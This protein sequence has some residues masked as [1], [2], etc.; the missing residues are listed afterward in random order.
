M[1]ER[2]AG[3]KVLGVVL[4]GIT[5]FTY[6][7]GFMLKFANIYFVSGIS[8]SQPYVE[9]MVI[10]ED[11]WGNNILE[12]T[13]FL[14]SLGLLTLISLR[15]IEIKLKYNIIYSVSLMAVLL[16]LLGIMPFRICWFLYT[17]SDGFFMPI[18]ILVFLSVINLA[19]FLVV[20]VVSKSTLRKL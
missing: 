9:E 5:V 15:G 2:K 19:C 3:P 17:L 18:F 12:F 14:I 10:Y 16:G 20:L 11:V 13:S 4:L 8:L 6:F 7:I 1:S